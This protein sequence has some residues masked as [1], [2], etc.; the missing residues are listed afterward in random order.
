MLR[1]ALRVI[2]VVLA[3]RRGRAGRSSTGSGPARRRRATTSAASASRPTGWGLQPQHRAG[4]LDQ[5]Q[6]GD[7]LE[8]V[9]HVLLRPRERGEGRGIARPSGR[10]T[11]R[12]ARRSSPGSASGRRSATSRTATPSTRLLEQLN[13]PK[14]HESSYRSAR[15]WRCRPTSSGGS[16][17]GST[18]RRR[19][20]RCSGSCPA[21]TGKWPVALQDDRFARERRAYERAVDAALEQQIAGKMSMEV[22]KGVKEA[23]EGLTRA[24]DA[25]VTPGQGPAL[26]RV[27]GPDQGAADDGQ[28]AREPARRAGAGRDRPA[29][30][31]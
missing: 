23:V 13:D 1:D 10:G 5:R 16:R 24:L 27:E 26:P 3:T 31:A 2:A 25:A 12:T 4:Q 9:R 28:A 14:I 22:I 30:R 19:S 8:R 17:S 29:T 15:R 11:R 20:S 6:H 21:G 18:R 7:P